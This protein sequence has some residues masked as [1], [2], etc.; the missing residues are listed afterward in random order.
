MASRWP[1]I[2][3]AR[4]NTTRTLQWGRVNLERGFITI[5]KDKTKAGTGRTVPLNTR[6]L[7][8]LHVWTKEFLDRWIVAGKPLHMIAR[9]LAGR[10]R[11][12]SIWLSGTA[13]S[14][15]TRDATVVEVTP[16]ATRPVR[17]PVR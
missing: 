12:W 9:L 1:S 10:R 7:Q 15:T 16:L 14:T 6:A 13:T 5:G 17:I 4:N 3:G 2:P 11:L 8:T